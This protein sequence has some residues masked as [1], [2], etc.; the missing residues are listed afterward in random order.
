MLW[1]IVAFSGVLT[2]RAL[3]SR[4]WLTMWVASFGLLP[5][6]LTSVGLFT[7]PVTVLQVGA[8]TAMRRNAS[9]W[10]WTAWIVVSLLLWVAV[11]TSASFTSFIWIGPIPMIPFSLLVMLLPLLPVE[12]PRPLN[13]HA[14]G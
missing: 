7:I 12:F 3:I 8:A 2:I 4:S 11:I 14:A 1:L 10:G 5:F 9:A 13:N 6:V